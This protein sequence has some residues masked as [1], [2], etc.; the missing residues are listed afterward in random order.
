MGNRY[1]VTGSHDVLPSDVYEADGYVDL[2]RHDPAG[3][4]LEGL[5]VRGLRSGRDYQCQFLTGDDFVV[6]DMWSGLSFRPSGLMTKGCGC[7]AWLRDEYWLRES[8]SNRQEFRHRVD[9]S[10]VSS[11]APAGV[12]ATITGLVRYARG[13]LGLVVRE[14]ERLD[15]LGSFGSLGSS[16]VP[17]RDVVYGQEGQAAVTVAFRW[18]GGVYRPVS[19][20]LSPEVVDAAW[21]KVRQGSV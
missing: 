1:E 20:L 2:K 12:P 16:A 5:V 10:E 9:W 13:R 18:G 19:G 14:Q 11:V 21:W 8:Y 17:S 15:P 4:Y 6:N 3:N 7:V